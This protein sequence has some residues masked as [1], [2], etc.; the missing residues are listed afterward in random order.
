MNK[1][2]QKLSG[3][4]PRELASKEELHQTVTDVL[5]TEANAIIAYSQYVGSCVTLADGVSYLLGTDGEMRRNIEALWNFSAGEIA[6]MDPMRIR[7]EWSVSNAME[8]M[9]RKGITAAN[10]EDGN[11]GLEG[12]LHIHDCIGGSVREIDRL[13]K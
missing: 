12:F 7:K 13:T 1:F 4:H 2:D 9:G 8:M 3:I 11:G 6:T 5:T 10:V